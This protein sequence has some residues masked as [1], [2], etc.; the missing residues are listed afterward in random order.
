VLAHHYDEA[1]QADKAIGYW[2][3]A[4]EKSVERSAN[5]EAMAQ[6]G[7]GLEL[8]QSLPASPERDRLELALRMPLGI[9]QIWA[10]GQGAPQV[11]DTYRQARELA[12]RLG[13]V[14]KTFGATLNLWIGHQ[15]RLELEPS[16]RE[17][18]ELLGIA[19]RTGD[20]DYLLQAHHSGW[21]TEF[22]RGALEAAQ[23]HVDEGLRI[24]DVERH[25]AHA[26]RFGGHDP[27]VCALTVRALSRWSLGFPDEA[28]AA[29]ARTVETANRRAHP[30]SSGH[31]RAFSAWVY[32]MRLEPEAVHRLAAEAVDF[33]AK[34][35]LSTATAWVGVA[36][37]LAC[38]AP[39]RLGD[40]LAGWKEMK[41]EIAQGANRARLWRTYC[42]GL[43]AEECAGVGAIEEGFS[44]IDEALSA[45]TGS[46]E[47]FWL[48]DLHR[49]RA[50]LL[51]RQSA[52]NRDEA[53]RGL[54]LALDVAG[55]QGARM[56]QLRAAT[57]LAR[58]FAETRRRTEALELLR[59]AYGAITEGHDTADLVA[60]RT[61][62]DALS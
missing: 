32:A 18:A 53:E 38:W 15:T 25:R 51:L 2:W 57:A 27:G 62:L 12:E 5:H 9:A 13:D 43:Y 23:G 44:A 17:S 52:A 61:L 26:L 31:A 3:R 4:G 42:L 59:P 30:N 33:F 55:S 45:A 19:R 49:V 8:V 34:Q 28:A 1:G 21:T 10:F 54:R 39:A 29:T 16:R 35:R 60:A 48:A 6:L 22:C 14:P 50:D 20:E 37:F 24:Y 36:K 11:A 7:R 40:R 46:G 41:D 58:L 56:L 47:Q